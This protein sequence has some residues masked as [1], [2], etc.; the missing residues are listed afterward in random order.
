MCLLGRQMETIYIQLVHSLQE[1]VSLYGN[2]FDLLQK[3]RLI[4]IDS[5]I[6]KLTDS[7]KTKEAILY[8]IRHTDKQRAFHA[9]Q[10]AEVLGVDK[11]QA[12]LLH[13]ADKMGPTRKSE[14]ETLRGLHKTLSL[15]IERVVELNAE[16]ENYTQ[17][18]LRILNGAIEDIK[19]AA[20][21]TKKKTYGKQGQTEQ[22][23]A[24]QS[25]N[26]VSKEA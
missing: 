1:L 26:F 14:T 9:E 7:N 16:N 11:S 19:E 5:N 4:L 8:K 15:Q 23:H 2:L 13:L 24:Q 18:V 25:G 6:E 20:V 10:L 17:T 12:R 21:G 3:E 22:S